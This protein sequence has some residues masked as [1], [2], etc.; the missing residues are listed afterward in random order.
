MLTTPPGGWWSAKQLGGA[1]GT[2][3]TIPDLSTAAKDFTSSGTARGTL[4]AT[5]NNGYPSIDLDGVD[6]GYATASIG[7]ASAWV[8]WIVGRLINYTTTKNIFSI[9]DYVPD[10]TY[11]LMQMNGANAVSIN[12]NVS[13]TPSVSAGAGTVRAYCIE[14]STSGVTIMVNDGTSA[15][16]AGNFTKAASIMRLG[17]RGDGLYANWGFSEAIYVPGTMTAAEKTQMWSYL[18]RQWG[19]TTP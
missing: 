6:D 9:D 13:G 8:F 19:V 12:S 5:G 18:N 16:A 10:S 7:S 3:T 2:I 1:T 17:R 11:I 4:N 14:G 15:T